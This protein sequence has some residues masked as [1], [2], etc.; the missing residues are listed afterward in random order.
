M[1]DIHYTKKDF[2]LDWYSGSGAGGQHRNRHMNCCRITH[3]KSGM[4]EKGT[5]SRSRVEN[6]RIAF[7]RLS[8]RVIAWVMAKENINKDTNN[9]IIRNYNEF[10]N[11][12]HD[13]CSGLKRPYNDIVKAGNL[14]EMIEARR[15]SFIK[16]RI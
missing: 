3:I 11:E 7:N 16:E 14:G 4:V 9:I 2:T 10:R 8:K 13:K 6:Q 5:E 15:N 1:E 12:V